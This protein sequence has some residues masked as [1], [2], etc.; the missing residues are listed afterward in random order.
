MRDA[1]QIVLKGYFDNL[2]QL[3]TIGFD[4][5]NEYI[6]RMISDDYEEGGIFIY[7]D[8]ERDQIDDSKKAG[9]NTTTLKRI[10]IIAYLIELAYDLSISPVYNVSES[11]G[12]KSCL[13]FH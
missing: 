12:F 7:N 11:P 13:H 2:T 1:N 9:R 10:N 5:G 3:I 4:V 8:N 6:N